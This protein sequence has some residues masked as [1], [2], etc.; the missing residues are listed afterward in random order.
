METVQEK[1][2]ENLYHKDDAGGNDKEFSSTKFDN[3]NGMISL[4][5]R[6]S[7]RW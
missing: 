2:E 3:G 6:Q 1:N 4:N 5:L 7:W